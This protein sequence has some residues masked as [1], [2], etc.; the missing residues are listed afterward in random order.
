MKS[1]NRGWS[2]VLRDLRVLRVLSR[3]LREITQG[4]E[5][6]QREITKRRLSRGKFVFRRICDQTMTEVS[7]I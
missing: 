4:E 3:M 7:L 1:K 6:F 5:R 2:R